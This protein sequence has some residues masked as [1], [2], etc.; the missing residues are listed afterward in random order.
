MSIANT[1]GVDTG[2]LVKFLSHFLGSH[3]GRRGRLIE[4]GI[5][6]ILVVS[7]VEKLEKSLEDIRIVFWQVDDAADGFLDVNSC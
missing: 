4:N 3:G 5:L 1:R 2:S 7:R 6:A